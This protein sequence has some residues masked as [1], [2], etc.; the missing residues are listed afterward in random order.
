MDGIKILINFL[1][2]VQFV[3]YHETNS[4]SINYRNLLL[5]FRFIF[6]FAHDLLYATVAAV[7]VWP[8]RLHGNAGL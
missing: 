6:V 8:S 1:N 3:T 5:F 2:S 7:I 4:N